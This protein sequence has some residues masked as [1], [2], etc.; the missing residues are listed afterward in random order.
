MLRFLSSKEHLEY[1]MPLHSIPSSSQTRNFH[2]HILQRKDDKQVVSFQCAQRWVCRSL[3]ADKPCEE[4]VG[5][6]CHSLVA[7]QSRTRRLWANR[8]TPLSRPYKTL[9]MGENSSTISSPLKK[10]FLMSMR[11]RFQPNNVENAN[12]IQRVRYLDKYEKGS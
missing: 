7:W 12:I 2:P 4:V 8:H 11:E 1:L 3:L 10:T 6:C 9:R 5:C